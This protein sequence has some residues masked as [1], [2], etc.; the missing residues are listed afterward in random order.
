MTLLDELDIAAYA[1]AWPDTLPYAVRKRVALARALVAKPRLLLLDEPAGGL[2]HEDIDELAALVNNLPGRGSGACSVM[3]VEHHMDLVMKVCHSIV[4][5]DFGRVIA[6]GT[7]RE[8]QDNP[9]VAE[10]YLGAEVEA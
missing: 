3:L 4:V 8:V 1:T 7:P 5:L 10:A 2:S 9:A 6:S